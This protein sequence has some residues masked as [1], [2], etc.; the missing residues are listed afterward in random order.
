MSDTGV[1]TVID[2]ASVRALRGKLQ[3]KNRKHRALFVLCVRLCII[4]KVFIARSSVMSYCETLK[5]IFGHH[6]TENATLHTQIICLSI[7]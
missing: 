1:V 2:G 4:R 3:S 5:M 7:R 6:Q